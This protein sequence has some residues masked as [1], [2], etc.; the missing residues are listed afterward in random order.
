MHIYLYD[1]SFEGFLTAVFYAYSETD[2][3]DI[4]REMDYQPTLLSHPLTLPTENDKAQRVLRS[5]QDKLSEETLDNLYRLYLS[6]IQ[7]WQYLALTY[8][9]LCYQETAQINMAKNHEIIHQ[10]DL[11]RR[12]VGLEA[13]RFKGFVRFDQA[14]PGLYYAKIEPDHNVLPLLIGHFTRRFSDQQFMIHDLKRHYALVYD[15]HKPYFRD[16]TP[17]D[18][19][20]LLAWLPND[21]F[22]QL[23]KVFFEAINI[24]ERAN[25]K[26]QLGYMPRR[27]WKHLPETN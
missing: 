16:L 6:E 4:Q 27:Y 18:E 10:V 9:K 3:C 21:E 7:G 8:L 20:K 22:A 2:L 5:V 26:Q 17:A 25:A 19:S 23:F 11:Y 15:L 12:K 24:P 14:G 1:G 13:Q